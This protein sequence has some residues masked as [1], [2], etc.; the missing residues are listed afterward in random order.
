MSIAYLSKDCGELVHS[1]VGRGG[2][3]I[4]ERVGYMFE[5]DV[6]RAFEAKGFEN[7]EEVLIADIVKPLS[8]CSSFFALRNR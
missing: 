2:D 6:A 5:D 1:Q 4:S 7:C 3:D 8:L